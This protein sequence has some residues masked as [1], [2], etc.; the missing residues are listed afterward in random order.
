MRR[1]RENESETGGRERGAG[2]DG[3]ETGS[4]KH[5]LG[6]ETG[7]PQERAGRESRRKEQNSERAPGERSILGD[8][9]VLQRIS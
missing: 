8:D 5:Q 6:G 7:R 9:A 3:S 2:A 4:R 1:E